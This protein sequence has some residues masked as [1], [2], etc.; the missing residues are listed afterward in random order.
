MNANQAAGRIIMNPGIFHYAAGLL[1]APVLLAGCVT[2]GSFKSPAPLSV[3]G[4]TASAMPETTASA[5]SAQGE[6]QKFSEGVAVEAQWWRA[7][8]S[9]KLDDLIERAL[10][11]SPTLLAAEA[12]LRQ[13]RYTYEA[14]SGSTRLPQVYANLGGKR[15]AVNNAAMGQPDGEN[16]FNLF[17]ASVNVQYHFDL[18]GGNRRALEALAAQAEF[19]RFKLEGARLALAAD[20]MVAAFTQAELAAQIEAAERI[21][22]AQ[23]EQLALVRQSAA[24][25][26]SSQ[27]EVLAQQTQMEQT[28]ASLPA[29]R[30]RLDQ[31]AHWL[32]ALTG[33]A[34][35]AADLP[36][37]ALEDFTL[38]ADLPL[39]I[40]S[41][42]VRSRPDI[43][44]SEALLLA[45]HAQ[46][47]V[48]VS[49]LYPQITLSADMGSQALSADKL[50]GAGSM[51]WA[52]AGQLAQPL[53]NGGLRDEAR[54]AEAGSEA[55]AAYYRETVLQAFRNVADVLRMLEHDA[56]V[57]AALAAV[58]NSS[59]ESLALVQW[60]YALGAASEHE[61][62][63]A[64]QQVALARTESIA[65]RAQRL[66]DT[67]AF[68]AAMGGGWMLDNAPADQQQ[69]HQEADGKA[70]KL[71]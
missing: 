50:F 8:G 29:L 58:E 5:P 36:Q 55:A 10:E 23:E 45:A 9:Q 28:R 41:E 34:P 51:I 35:S 48:A 61:V 59:Q 4:Y 17:N 25:G 53:F 52:L 24:L 57:L 7:F 19:Q 30:N 3:A 68:Y 67:A 47:G 70:G 26:S 13:A 33:Q 40:P 32:A 14:Q 56:Q 37:F 43:R 15:Q 22:S 2:G 42:L 31:T 27:N 11:A 18:F 66:I 46:H 60:K 21:L 44:A 65:A 71:K 54:A 1:C 38:P 39:Q 69:E 63:T 16:T 20:A 12:T 49:K 64:Q 6:A 62:L